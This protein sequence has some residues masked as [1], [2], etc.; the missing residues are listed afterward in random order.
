MRGGAEALAEERH[1][2]VV[3]KRDLPVHDV[4]GVVCAVRAHVPLPAHDVI[5]S[6]QPP[7][8]AVA[9]AVENPP[10]DGPLLG[11]V[12]RR[13]E[14]N[15]YDAHAFHETSAKPPRS[16]RRAGVGAYPIVSHGRP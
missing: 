11:E 14:K 13:G 10:E 4:L 6:S 2:D 9:D 12:H 15:L 7:P 5:A 3:V 8:K 1:K 16:P